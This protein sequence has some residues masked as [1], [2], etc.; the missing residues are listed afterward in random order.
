[1][2]HC[3]FLLQTLPHDNHK[4][5]NLLGGSLYAYE[6]PPVENIEPV[7]AEEETLEKKSNIGLSEI[8]RGISASKYGVN[9]LSVCQYVKNKHFKNENIK[10]FYILY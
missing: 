1:M 7:T 5:R 4:I 3:I 6:L 9:I 10:L 2:K 8:Q